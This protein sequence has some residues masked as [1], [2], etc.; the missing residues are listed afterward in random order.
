MLGFVHGIWRQAKNKMNLSGNV[1]NN[2]K[3]INYYVL[4][5]LYERT[6]FECITDIRTC[7]YLK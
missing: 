7:I 4:L 3:F 2:Y 6:L 5:R 1:L